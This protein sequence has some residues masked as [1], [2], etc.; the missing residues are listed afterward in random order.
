MRG[1][2]DTAAPHNPSSA[3]RL[4]ETGMTKKEDG[5]RIDVAA[6][7]M[8][9]TLPKA[10]R[11]TAKVYTRARPLIVHAKTAACIVERGSPGP[12]E[13]R[14][15]RTLAKGEHLALAVVPQVKGVPGAGRLVWAVVTGG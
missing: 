4:E 2:V 15:L 13:S 7:S 9:I 5:R 14:T 1:G 8:T 10:D 12:Q 6:A 11:E 3:C